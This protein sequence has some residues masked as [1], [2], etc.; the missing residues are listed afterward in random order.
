MMENSGGK[1]VALLVDDEPDLLESCARIL[2]SEGYRCITAENGVDVLELAKKHK[3]DI[4][5]TDFMMPK[6]NG[7]EVLR[8]ITAEFPELPVVMISAFATI[9]GVVAAVKEGAFD[10][11]T[12][13][14]SADQLVITVDRAV[15]QHRLRKENIALRTKVKN[16]FFSHSFVGRS[17]EIMRITDL[18]KKVAVTESNVLIEGEAGAGKGLVAWA[19]HLHG[20]GSSTPFV[21]VDCKNLTEESGKAIESADGGVLYLA[22]IDRIDMVTQ[23]WL[24]KVLHEKRESGGDNSGGRQ[25]KMRVISSTCENLRSV[26]MAGAFRESLYYLL[27][28]IT[29]K[30]PP[31]RERSDDVEVLCDLFLSQSA[32]NTGA[33][34]K[35]LRNDT[36]LCLMDYDW[37]G[38]VRELRS[39]IEMAVSMADGDFIKVTDLPERVRNTGL[40]EDLSYKDAKN[41]W[42]KSFERSYLEN[43][44][45]KNQGNISRSSREAG[46]ARMSL[47]R[48]IKRNNLGGLAND[49][50]DSG[51]GS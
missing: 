23:A 37:P 11:L 27:G 42:L 2:T 9:D 1:G 6:K 26:M 33:V 44:L 36:L 41:I 19:I 50:R 29:I 40:M 51:E 17:R 39:V 31:L 22:N 20:G 16:D 28:V 5:V 12:K 48:M 46:I 35:T 3:P 4:V 8:E 43:L 24:N 34:R 32:E 45:L 49:E 47:Y 30:I 10:Y 21:T 18:V 7:M 25:P 15:S 14:F 38:N 13:P